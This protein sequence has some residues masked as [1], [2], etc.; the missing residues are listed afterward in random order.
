MLVKKK[1]ERRLSVFMPL[2]IF[3]CMFVIWR[4]G[5]H[6][7]RSLGDTGKFCWSKIKPTFMC[8]YMFYSSLMVPLLAWRRSSRC[9]LKTTSW[10]PYQEAWSLAPSLTSHY[11]ITLGAAPASWP[12]CA[13][14]KTGKY[15]KNLLY[16][17]CWGSSTNIKLSVRQ[18]EV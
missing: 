1:A 11:P 5:Q 9:T 3:S 8:N 14:R 17:S 18:E 15:T 16:N 4:Y 13:G 12:R 10:G 6:I 7:T 2:E